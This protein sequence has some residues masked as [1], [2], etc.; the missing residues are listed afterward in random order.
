MHCRLR[1]SVRRLL[2]IGRNSWI[3]IDCRLHMLDYYSDLWIEALGSRI[4]HWTE[5][6]RVKGRSRHSG[7]GKSCRNEINFDGDMSTLLLTDPVGD[8]VLYTFSRISHIGILTLHCRTIM[9]VV[10]NLQQ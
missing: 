8:D 1:M 10:P 6:L 5:E 3:A 4:S 7:R 2:T 9:Q